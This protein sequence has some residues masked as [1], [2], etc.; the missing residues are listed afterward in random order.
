MNK[1]QQDLKD[2][3]SQAFRKGWYEKVVPNSGKLKFKP[4]VEIEN[5]P[6]GAQKTVKKYQITPFIVVSNSTVADWYRQGK[7]PGGPVLIGMEYQEA[8]FPKNKTYVLGPDGVI[9]HVNND[10]MERVPDG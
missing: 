7:M 1:T 3:E 4:L 6:K 10:Y 8:L 9:L 5:L 2:A